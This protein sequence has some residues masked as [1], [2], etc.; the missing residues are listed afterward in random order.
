MSSPSKKQKIGSS[1]ETKT[2]G[3]IGLG[4]M[5]SHLARHL[6]T[7]SE[8][9]WGTK[10]LVWNRTLE[11]AQEHARA[12]GTVAVT[13]LAELGSCHVLCL[14][15]PTTAH[16]K[17]VLNEVPLEPDSLVIDMTSGD[18]EETRELAAKL[19]NVRD[20]H[21]VDAPVSGGPTGA[22]AGTVT[23]MLGGDPSDIA[24]AS[25]VCGA[26]SKKVV[27]CGPVGAGDATKSINNVM[28]SAHLLLATEG[29]LALKKYGV[30]PATAVEVINASS[31]ASL[32]V[33]RL[34][35][36]VLS[37]KFAYGFALG[38]MH[39]DCRI[40]GNLVARQ[41]PDAILIPKVVALLGEAEER[42]GPNADYTQIAQ[43]LEER[44][45]V[46]LG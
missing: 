23:S 15:L 43:L 14:C 30:E 33:Q 44:A 24:L 32:Q 11:T 27:H 39:K 35:D 40:A 1:H 9:E 42:Y 2:V 21:F 45:G 7:F 46:T 26:W 3:F 17:A 5:G 41:T 22:A 4:A 31:G 12:H 18:P 6:N 13:T 20:V 37:R 25:R 8:K 19:E 36:N 29:M 16:V 10:A 34:P 38:L 28:N